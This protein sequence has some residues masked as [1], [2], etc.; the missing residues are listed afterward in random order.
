MFICL[1]LLLY[2]KMTEKKHHIFPIL[3]NEEI[4]LEEILDLSMPLH[5]DFCLQ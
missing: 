4:E 2:C 5:Q 3:Q 1:Y